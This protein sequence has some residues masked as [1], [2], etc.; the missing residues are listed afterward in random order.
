MIKRRH[1]ARHVEWLGY[2][3]RPEGAQADAAGDADR[4][5][6]DGQR[7]EAHTAF[8]SVSRRAWRETRKSKKD[9][10]EF[11]LLGLLRHLQKIRWR[12]DR[13]VGYPPRGRMP[14]MLPS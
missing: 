11:S 5:A 10:V 9:D 12:K 1:D 3:E 4:G 13:R 2:V 6:H 8:A 7:F 14:A